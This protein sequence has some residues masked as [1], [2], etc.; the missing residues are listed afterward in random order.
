MAPTR[1]KLVKG[2]VF[3]KRVPPVTW[4]PPNSGTACEEVRFSTLIDESKQEPVKG[5]S[6][7]DAARLDGLLVG[8]L[9]WPRL[10]DT[11]LVRDLY[12]SSVLRLFFAFRILLKISFN[13]GGDPIEFLLALRPLARLLQQK[14][15]A[16]VKETRATN[17]YVAFRNF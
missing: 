17:H 7:L 12:C 2:D 11:E 1:S 13:L 3:V 9:D 14:Q 5:V 8:E 16:G 6:E 4:L 15:L 10:G